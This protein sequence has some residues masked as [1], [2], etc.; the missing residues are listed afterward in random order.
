MGRSGK[1]GTSK[2]FDG[3]LPVRWNANGGD[4]AVRFVS[5]RKSLR[6]WN[7]ILERVNFVCMDGFEFLAKCKDEKGHGIYVDAPWPDDG[8]EYRF[9]FTETMQR[10]LAMRLHYYEKSRVVIRYGDHPLIRELYPESDWTW[11]RVVGRTSGNNRKAEV[12]LVNK[13]GG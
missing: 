3:D 7:R 11:D 1:T 13:T 5:A 9:A 8:D 6:E 2:E 12:L 10:D 4:S